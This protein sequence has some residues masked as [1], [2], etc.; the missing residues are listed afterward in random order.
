MAYR[1]PW[2]FAHVPSLLGCQIRGVCGTLQLPLWTMAEFSP[3]FIKQTNQLDMPR[4]WHYW[5]SCLL[6]PTG[7][8]LVDEKHECSELHYIYIYM[9]ISASW[10]PLFP[11]KEQGIQTASWEPFGS[12]FCFMA[13][14]MS[15][16]LIL[17]WA[18]FF[19][20]LWRNNKAKIFLSLS[21][22]DLHWTTSDDCV[23]G[24]R[25]QG[26]STWLDCWSAS[27][28]LLRVLRWEFGLIHPHL[29]L[30]DFSVALL[31]SQALGE[32]SHLF[33]LRELIF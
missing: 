3:S 22:W 19:F 25:A 5:P 17:A 23:S 30:G 13:S 33:V 29:W 24:S 11:C 32:V 26:P 12:V 28:Q 27:N 14:L 18:L 7:S 20:N 16:L 1:E 2:S 4:W 10:S 6:P 31:C 21:G 15:Y 9:Y 8:V